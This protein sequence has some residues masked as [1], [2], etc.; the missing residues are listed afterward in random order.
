MYKKLKTINYQNSVAYVETRNKHERSLIR[1]FAHKN[2]LQWSKF[3]NN[4]FVKKIGYKCTDCGWMFISDDNIWKIDY[5]TTPPY[6]IYGFYVKCKNN[7]PNVVYRDD[8][9]IFSGF[10][11]FNITNCIVVG[12]NLYPKYKKPVMFQLKKK[13]NDL[14]WIE[15]FLQ[16]SINK[17]WCCTLEKSP[18]DINLL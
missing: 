14:T 1:I 2:N 13:K 16:S 18:K 5:C 17:I 7:C 6:H 9:P 15:E 3:N 8:D 11:K 12:L 10:K 4:D